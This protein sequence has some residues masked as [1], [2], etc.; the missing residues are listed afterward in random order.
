[1]SRTFLLFA[2]LIG[3]SAAAA[4]NMTAD[5]QLAARDNLDNLPLCATYADKKWQPALDF[6]KDSCYNV[7][8]ISPSGQV[9]GGLNVVG[10]AGITSGCRDRQDVER[11]N[12]YSR[13]RCN[14]GWCAHMYGYYFEKDQLTEIGGGHRHDWEHVIVWTKNDQMQYVSVSQHGEYITRGY[15]HVQRDGTH[16][17]IVYHKD[18]G[19]THVMRLANASDGGAQN[20]LG[21]WTYG[22]LVSYYGFPSIS[23][24]SKLMSAG[25]GDAS[26]DFNDARFMDSL[27][28]GRPTPAFNQGFDCGRD[29]PEDIHNSPGIPE[30]G[31]GVRS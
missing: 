17:K 31:C 1:M 2:G 27:N 20:H 8:A 6:D 12:V 15:Q 23:L 21:R 3:F 4:I 13:T 19:R 26:I 7:A 24:R 30:G 11:T 28:K 10:V 9:N 22:T 29:G 14:H 16:V 5:F 18:G 25:F